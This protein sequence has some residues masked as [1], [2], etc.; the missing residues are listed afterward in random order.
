MKNSTIIIKMN[1]EEEARQMFNW[2]KQ[3]FCDE[4][5]IGNNLIIPKPNTDDQLLNEMVEAT[6]SSNN[7]DN[8]TEAATK[9]TGRFR[10]GIVLHKPERLWG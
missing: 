1:N 8:R 3:F 4:Y 6:L 9:T 5:L 7:G 2:L 10:H